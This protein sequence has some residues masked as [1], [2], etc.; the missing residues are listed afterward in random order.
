MVKCLQIQLVMLTLLLQNNA[1]RA[2][3]IV[4]DFVPPFASKE[5][6]L[7]YIDDITAS[8]ERII[9]RDDDIAEVKL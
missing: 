7:A 4:K 2:K 6:Y 8:G 5:E 9:Y 1:Q 3:R